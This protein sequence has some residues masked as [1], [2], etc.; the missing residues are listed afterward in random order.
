M[1]LPAYH[2]IVGL[3]SWRQLH[4]REGM[5]VLRQHRSPSSEILRTNPYPESLGNIVKSLDQVIAATEGTR[6]YRLSMKFVKERRFRSDEILIYPC[7][8]DYH[9]SAMERGPQAQDASM[10][11]LAARFASLSLDE[12][13]W[14]NLTRFWG[15]CTTGEDSTPPEPLQSAQI[16][17]SYKIRLHWALRAYRLVCVC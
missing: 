12:A 16:G 4:C 15:Y 14:A 17:F 3:G 8:G 11:S 5:K 6:L 7:G 2:K 1:G 13:T 10:M 9:P